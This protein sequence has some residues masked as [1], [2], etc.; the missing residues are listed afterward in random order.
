ADRVETRQPSWIIRI[1][2]TEQVAEDD[3]Y[4]AYAIPD[5]LMW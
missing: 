2:P 1:K 3:P 4:A 5:D